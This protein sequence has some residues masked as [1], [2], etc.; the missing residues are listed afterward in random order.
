MTALLQVRGLCLD[1]PT[2]RG[3]I[4]M[5]IASSSRCDI[6]LAPTAK[7]RSRGRSPSG[8]SL[9]N[10]WYSALGSSSLPAAEDVSLMM[11]TVL[12]DA[13]PLWL[14]EIL[15]YFVQYNRA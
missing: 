2:P 14:A 15:N 11:S 4:R 7:K 5:R 9:I 13:K 3:P 8:M 6:A 1:A 10:T 12:K